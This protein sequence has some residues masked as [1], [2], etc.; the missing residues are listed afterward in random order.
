MT[1][2]AC[3]CLSELLVVVANRKGY[4]EP[5]Q[6]KIEKIGDGFGVLL[7][8]EMM[9]AC[10]FG[11]EATVIVQDKTLIVSPMPR[12]TRE[13]WAEAARRM[14]ERGDDLTPEMQDWLNVPDEWAKTEW[15]WPDPSANEKV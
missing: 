6:T 14:R 4:R 8:K 15:Q 11:G 1:T 3:Q 12:Q 9:E 7:P 5:M 10:G 2:T 13:G